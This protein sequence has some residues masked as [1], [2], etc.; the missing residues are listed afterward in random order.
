MRSVIG[1]VCAGQEDP[2]CCVASAVAS[3]WVRRR[4]CRYPSHARAGWATP[5]HIPGGLCCAV[6][7]GNQHCARGT[8]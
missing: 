1:V 3:G 4:F 5:R 2:P 7:G 6:I 8:V